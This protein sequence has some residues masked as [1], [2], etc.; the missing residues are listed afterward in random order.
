MHFCLLNFR[1]YGVVIVPDPVSDFM[2]IGSDFDETYPNIQPYENRGSNRYYIAAG[3]NNLSLVP[4]EFRAG[5]KSRTTAI[6]NG[7][8]ENYLNA[9]LKP[10]TTY[11]F[12]VLI[13][14]MTDV[15]NVSCK[16]LPIHASTACM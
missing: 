1:Y 2:F 7:I 5:D 14:H 10:L 12:Y 16:L 9:E 8:E 3:W 15:G 6:R 13:H 11:C 4:E